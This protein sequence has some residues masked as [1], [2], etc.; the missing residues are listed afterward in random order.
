MG[1]FAVMQY[2]KNIKIL[3]DLP[4]FER[5]GVLISIMII[6]TYSFLLTVGGAYK[7]VSHETKVHCR[8][9][10]AHLLS[11][12]PWIKFPYPLEWGAPTF[13]A[14]HSFAMMSAVIVSQIEVLTVCC[15]IYIV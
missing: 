2:L 5:F 6:W 13:N 4:V 15:V 1:Y 9:D 7:H 12:T 8:T 3:K 14:G 11:S 10:S